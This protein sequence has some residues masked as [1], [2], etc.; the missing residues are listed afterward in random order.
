MPMCSHD[1][2]QVSACERLEGTFTGE[3]WKGQGRRW[4]ISCW[5]IQFDWSHEE[6]VMGEKCLWFNHRVR[7]TDLV[8]T[9]MNTHRYYEDIQSTHSQQIA[10]QCECCRGDL[11]PVSTAG[12][13]MTPVGNR[14]DVSTC[15]KA[16]LWS[17]WFVCSDKA[18]QFKLMF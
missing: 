15:F 11:N 6:K 3:W 2:H 13:S 16:S 12:V 17:G 5:F 7:T 14:R 4:K 9:C 18:T 10:H 8:S 1:S